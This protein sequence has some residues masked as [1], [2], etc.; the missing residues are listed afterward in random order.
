[1]NGWR[2]PR[3]LLVSLAAGLLGTGW[4]IAAYFYQPVAHRPIPRHQ[5]GITV[6]LEEPVDLPAIHP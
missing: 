4:V 2:P 5:G 6:A 1:M 3:D